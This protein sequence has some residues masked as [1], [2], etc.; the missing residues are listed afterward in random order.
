METCEPE[1]TEEAQGAIEVNM[2]Y[3]LQLKELDIPEEEAKK[4]L[5]VTGNISAEEAAIFY[6]E[7]LE[8][9]NEIAA[10]VAHAAV[11][12]Y[13]ILIKES[14]TREMAYKW[15][16]YGAKKVVLQGSS[17][18]HLL[19]LQALALSMNLP[20][21]LVQDAGRTQIAAGSYTVLSIMGEEESVNKV[22]GKLKLLN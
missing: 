9:M 7:N 14:K 20:N 15:D 18:A 4:A 22:T 13:Q 1:S 8:R 12:L 19:E 3:L 17:T 5:I 10:Q 11:G 21:Y 2:E 16:N 6:F